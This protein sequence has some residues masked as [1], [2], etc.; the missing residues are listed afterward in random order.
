MS[1]SV[2]C[3]WVTRQKSRQLA[4]LK[5]GALLL[6]ERGRVGLRLATTCLLL[7]STQVRKTDNSDLSVSTGSQSLR[8]R[9]ERKD[10]AT[11]WLN[12]LL[13]KY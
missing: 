8:L 4:V 7:P 1:E 2:R 5:P 3:V 10:L 11:E 6:Y 9:L 12:A 13:E